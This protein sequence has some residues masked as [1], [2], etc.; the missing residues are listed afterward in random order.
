MLSP[1]ILCWEAVVNVRH[2][3]MNECDLKVDELALFSQIL[4]VPG[5]YL[6]EYIE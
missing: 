2:C 1:A 4:E 6:G 3:R 5:S